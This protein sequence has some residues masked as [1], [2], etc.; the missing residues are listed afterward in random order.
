MPL[1]ITRQKLNQI[2]RQQSPIVKAAF[3]EAFDRIRDEATL[4][5]VAEAIAT[6]NVNQ[7]MSVLAVG[8]LTFRPFDDAL[9]GVYGA[10]GA[11]AAATVKMTFDARSPRSEAWFRSVT[12]GTIQGL[13][14][15]LRE[16]IREGI[17]RGAT[18]GLNP[19]QTAEQI[20][21]GLGLTRNQAQWVANARQEL[22]SLD[23]MAD[24][25]ERVQRNTS[26]DDIVKSAIKRGA[27]LPKAA[28][29]QLAKAYE[30]RLIGMRAETIARTETLS[31]I[32]QGQY[33]AA[34]QMI[35][36]GRVDR[37]DIRYRWDATGDSRTRSSHAAMEGQEVAHGEA[38][39]A[40][41][42]ARLRYPRDKSL[43]APASETINCRCWVDAVV[44]DGTV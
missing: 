17:A 32:S 3:L 38:F 10:A 8:E 26:L 5:A 6:G 2:L 12:G 13:T 37:S 11:E 21:S 41:S 34:D 4:R 24:Y 40:P 29:Q 9:R 20:R 44:S 22:A 23:T 28:Q 30:V 7:V 15:E 35:A 39:I 14:D 25:L 27:P 31:A 42:G 1:L 43:G 16:N 18:E 36:E 33:D 19:R